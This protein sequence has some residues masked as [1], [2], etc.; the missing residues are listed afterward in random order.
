MAGWEGRR[1]T[2]VGWFLHNGR[3]YRALQQ[4]F[5]S[6]SSSSSLCPGAEGNILVLKIIAASRLANGA[7]CNWKKSRLTYKN[8][9]SNAHF[10]PYLSLFRSLSLFYSALFSFL[11]PFL[12]SRLAASPSFSRTFRLPRI[13]IFL[14]VTGTLVRPVILT[15]GGFCSK[16]NQDLPKFLFPCIILIPHCWNSPSSA[17][18]NG[19]NE[20]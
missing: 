3:H 20:E 2:G 4:C 8:A 19:I 9:V 7:V 12:S 11:L 13:R 14:A 16:W 6:F 1:D 18:A 15:N 5:P 17:I 10:F